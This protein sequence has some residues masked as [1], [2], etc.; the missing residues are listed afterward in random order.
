MFAYFRN[1]DNASAQGVWNCSKPPR[2]RAKRFALQLHDSDNFDLLRL[3]E[4]IPW[5]RQIA[6]DCD[7]NYN[8]AIDT[9]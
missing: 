9:D 6:I 4:K 1:D 2:L 7:E 5:Q 3:M 8:N